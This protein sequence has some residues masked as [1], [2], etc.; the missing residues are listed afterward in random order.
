MYTSPILTILAGGNG[1]A[2]TYI[3]EK[4]ETSFSLRNPKL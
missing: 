2:L 4:I 1:K 3:D